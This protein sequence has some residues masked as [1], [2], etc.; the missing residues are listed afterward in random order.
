VVQLYNSQ[1]AKVKTLFAGEAQAKKTYQLEW[2][3]ANQNAAGLY[4]IRLQTKKHNQ[5]LKILHSK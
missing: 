4:I 5:A 1:G 3:P 2:L